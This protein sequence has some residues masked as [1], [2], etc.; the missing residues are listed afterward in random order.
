MIYLDIQ[1]MCEN[2]RHTLELNQGQRESQELKQ[3]TGSNG[4][5]VQ[6]DVQQFD[7]IFSSLEQQ[8]YSTAIA[9]CTS[10][11]LS[12]QNST[13]PEVAFASSHYY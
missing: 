13:R 2:Q 3:Q 12:R 9:S 10:T 6:P 11:P 8:A 7:N 4:Q 1:T 5:P